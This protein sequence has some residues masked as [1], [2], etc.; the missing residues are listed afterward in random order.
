MVFRPFNCGPSTAAANGL[1]LAVRFFGTSN[2]AWLNAFRLTGLADVYEFGLA[3]GG[4]VAWLAL[5]F[6][7]P[8]AST[9]L[10]C[11]TL[12]ELALAAARVVRRKNASRFFTSP[13]R[14]R[15]K[16]ESSEPEMPSVQQRGHRML[17]PSV[18]SGMLRST[19]LA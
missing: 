13:I 2:A 10:H 1:S 17:R 15:E 5:P 6:M 3:G 11:T 19:S 7:A 8:V 12:H 9:D 18:L 14:L 4:R 16:S